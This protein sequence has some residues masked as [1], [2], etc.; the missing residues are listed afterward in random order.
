MV[1]LHRIL[2]PVDFSDTSNAALRYGIALAR[3]FSARLVVLYVDDQAGLGLDAAFPLEPV[4][5]V[6]RERLVG[7][8]TPAERTEF[9]PECAVAQG[10][11]AAQIVE[12]ARDHEIDLIV[13][14]TH[15]R[16]FVGHLVMGSVAE[17]VVRTAPCP[18]LTL[19]NGRPALVPE[20]VRQPI[21]VA[22]G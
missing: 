18:V 10:H 9:N 3:T 5:D 4:E 7:L 13:M 12:Y 16:G 14:G 15:G 19:R 8:F 22:I 6:T 21:A 2:I 11:A 1:V 20:G 17:K